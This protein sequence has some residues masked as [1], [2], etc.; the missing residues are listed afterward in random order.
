[1]QVNDIIWTKKMTAVM[2]DTSQVLY[3]V[4]ATGCSKSLVAGIKFM[5]WLYEAPKGENQFYMI[6]YD[7]ITFQSQ[8]VPVSEENTVP[9]LKSLRLSASYGRA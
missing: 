1:M 7:S 2:Q 4:G 8:I 3:L 9:T 6:F 5:Q